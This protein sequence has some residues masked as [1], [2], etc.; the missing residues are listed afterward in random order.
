MRCMST[1]LGSAT[2]G[3]RCLRMP[4]G[5][6]SRSACCAAAIDFARP[7]VTGITMPGNSTKLRTGTM[8]IA[9]AGTGG[10]WLSWRG[11][12]GAPP[13]RPAP[14]LIERRF[15]NSTTESS[16]L[17]GD[18]QTAIR[19]RP[20]DIDVASRRQPHAPFEAA[21]RQFEAMDGRGLKLGGQHAK[22]RHQ[23]AI[24]LDDRLDSIGVDAGQGDEDERRAVRLQ[25]VSYTH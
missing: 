17:Q 24:I 5:R 4:T 12:S 10:S 20:A 2:S 14:S 18:Q 13:E 3:S 1:A 8:I 9:S 16:L 22:T 23:K 25:P 7:T 11:F 19:H 21:L 6:C 15:S